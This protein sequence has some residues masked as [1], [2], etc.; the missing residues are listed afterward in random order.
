VALG[1]GSGTFASFNAEVAN[2]GNYFQT[3]TLF[4]HDSANGGNTC[5]S[6][7]AP[8]NANVGTGDNCDYIFHVNPTDT[9]ATAPSYYRVALNNAGSIDATKLEFYANNACQSNAQSVDDGSVNGTQT[10]SNTITVHNLL[11]GIPANTSIKVGSQTVNTT[12]AVSPDA[13]EI[14]VDS[15]I[16]VTDGDVISY[17]PV[18]TDVGDGNLC[19][20]LQFAIWEMPDGTDV[21]PGDGTCIYA[22]GC[23][24]TGNTLDTIPAAASGTG[25]SLLSGGGLTHATTRYLLIGINPPTSL[26]NSYQNR[27]A[28]VD[29]AWH[30]EQ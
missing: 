23:T 26:D 12:Q 16:A 4:L 11:Y 9:G 20:K 5:T 15:A 19:T 21:D 18:F 22:G 13:T 1:G 28:T 10:S 2:E 17:S 24:W 7:S 27:K 6:E 14:H 25:D 3:G 30:I 29:I 8:N